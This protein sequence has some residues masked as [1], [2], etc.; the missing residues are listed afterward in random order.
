MCEVVVCSVKFNVSIG[1]YWSVTSVARVKGGM[2]KESECSLE[3]TAFLY[4]R[5]FPAVVVRGGKTLASGAFI[6]S[7]HAG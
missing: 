5:F 6:S 7:L 3:D 1:L 2:I 4:M